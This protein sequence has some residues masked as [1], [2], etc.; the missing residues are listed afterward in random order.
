MRIRGGRGHTGV[1][2]AEQP[3]GA[4]RE[5]NS[6]T[7]DPEIESRQLAAA[8]AHLAEGKKAGEIRV[9]DV[10]DQ[11]KFADYFVL[12]TASSRPQVRAIYNELHTRLKA[13]G[14]H[15]ARAEGVELGWWILLDY[16]DVV[17]HI[18][19]PEARSYYDLDTLYGESKELD[20]RSVELPPLPMPRR[21]QAS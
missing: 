2:R 20:W 14:E 4:P 15:H 11:L 3:S 21:A 17:V 16:G 5:P 1:P 13:A 6:L 10:A 7:G 19:Q 12:V 9:L 18:L 8:A